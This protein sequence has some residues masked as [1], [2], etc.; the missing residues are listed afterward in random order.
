MSL[1][2]IFTEPRGD[3]VQR[4]SQLHLIYGP[5]MLIK[6][7][8]YFNAC[9]YY[10]YLKCSQNLN[11]TVTSKPNMASMQIYGVSE[12]RMSTENRIILV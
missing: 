12:G 10:Y 8:L 4:L 2:V 7:R 6:L 5:T 11:F 9:V 1:R 3:G